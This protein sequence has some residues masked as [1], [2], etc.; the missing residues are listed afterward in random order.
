[1]G[2]KACKHD[3]VKF[4]GLRAKC[5]RTIDNLK[6]TDLELNLSECPRNR[7][8]MYVMRDWLSKETVTPMLKQSRRMKR[9]HK[10]CKNTWFGWVPKALKKIEDDRAEREQLRQ[11]AAEVREE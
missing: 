10:Y 1:M 6:L 3:F 7:Q 9:Y 5:R 2:A 11:R 4:V 8:A